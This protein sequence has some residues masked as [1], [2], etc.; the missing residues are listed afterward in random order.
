MATVTYTYAPGDA[1]FRLSS[2]RTI[3]EMVVKT[4]IIHVMTVSTSI[5]YA[6][7]SLDGALNI[8]VPESELY[9]DA[10]AALAAYKIQ[11]LS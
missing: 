5:S 3:T 9:I 6:V 2:D 1:V 8:V 4:V 7:V 10:D 11:F